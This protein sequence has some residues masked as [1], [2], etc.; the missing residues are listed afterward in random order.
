MDMS[1]CDTLIFHVWTRGSH[2]HSSRVFFAFVKYVMFVCSLCDILVL[3]L[4]WNVYTKKINKLPIQNTGSVLIN[5]VISS[6]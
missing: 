3:Q 4:F 1:I 2:N 6:I 5:V